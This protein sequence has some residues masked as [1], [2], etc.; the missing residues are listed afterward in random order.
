MGYTFLI[1]ILKFWEMRIHMKC[2]SLTN[3]I[4]YICNIFNSQWL[5]HKQYEFELQRN[6]YE[7][8]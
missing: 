8:K 5:I 1:Y 3:I 4:R 7:I 2:F 6:V